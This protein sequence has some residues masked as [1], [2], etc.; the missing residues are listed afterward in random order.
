MKMFYAHPESMYGT[1]QED[2]DVGVMGSMGIN[3]LNP[4][5]PDIQSIVSTMKEYATDD[6]I[7]I[8]VLS[9]IDKCE[10]VAF[11]A[12]ANGIPPEVQAAIEKC[13]ADKKP[14]IEMPWLEGRAVA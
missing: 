3:V 10:G 14:V 1:E 9:Q 5:S 11:R 6:E 13:Q 12:L 8:F 2:S 7:Q 4:N